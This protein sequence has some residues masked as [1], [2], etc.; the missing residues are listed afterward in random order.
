M[1]DS[2]TCLFCHLALPETFDLGSG[3]SRS[4]K[5]GPGRN[6]GLQLENS[7]NEFT[8]LELPGLAVSPSLDSEFSGG[9]DGTLSLSA[10]LCTINVACSFS[11][12]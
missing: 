9:G 6:P 12:L 11:A 10:S 4:G 8:C 1:N 3:Q 2:Q 5:G 7:G